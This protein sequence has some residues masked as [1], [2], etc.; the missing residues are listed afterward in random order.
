MKNPRKSPPHSE[1]ES[2]DDKKDNDDKESGLRVE[3]AG[4]I[5]V[6][7]LKKRVRVGK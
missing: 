1:S 3:D 2:N 5:K 7:N 4:G 6:L